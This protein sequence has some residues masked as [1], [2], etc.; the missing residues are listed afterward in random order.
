[1]MFARTAGL[2]AAIKMPGGAPKHLLKSIMAAQ[3]PPAILARRKMGFNPPM[4]R[5]IDQLKDRV[6]EYLGEHQLRARGYFRPE[7]VARML[8]MTVSE[9]EPRARALAERLERL[10]RAVQQ[11]VGVVGDHCHG[12]SELGR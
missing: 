10:V 7:V 5:W 4:G 8:S 2:P 1:M 12:H 3:L 9:I 11:A 6:D